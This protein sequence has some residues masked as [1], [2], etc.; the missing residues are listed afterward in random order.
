MNSMGWLVFLGIVILTFIVAWALLTKR[1]SKEQL[2]DL[3]HEEQDHHEAETEGSDHS[4]EKEADE[5]RHEMIEESIHSTDQDVQ[6]PMPASPETSDDLVEIE[7]IGPKIAGILGE[8]GITTFEQL[9]NTD[10]ETLRKILADA[11]LQMTDPASWPEQARLASME[12]KTALH[13]FQKRLK[14]GCN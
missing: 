11:R 1:P 10:V 6:V 9:A 3:G 13:E 8:A 2:N 14:G 12:D 7:G 4:T 5:T